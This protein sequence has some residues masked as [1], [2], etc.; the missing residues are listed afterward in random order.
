MRKTDKECNVPSLSNLSNYSVKWGWVV[1]AE[2]YDDFL[3]L[4]A[5]TENE[6]AIKEMRRRQAGESAEFQKVAYGLKDEL[7]GEKLRGEPSKKAW[8]L[9]T[10]VNAY[11]QSVMIEQDARGEPLELDDKDKRREDFVRLFEKAEKE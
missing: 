7:D 3:D 9:L 8:V 6:L 1:R 10:L 5:R 2:A 4:N 11:G